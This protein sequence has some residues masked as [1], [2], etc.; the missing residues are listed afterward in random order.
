MTLYYGCDIPEDLFYHPDYDC[1]V[2]FE[3]DQTVTLGMTDIAQTLAGKLLHVRF[4]GVGRK[5]K[6]G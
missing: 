4:K 6:A 5:V 1:W 3:A 2:R